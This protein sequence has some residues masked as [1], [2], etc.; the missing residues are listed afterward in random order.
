MGISRIL[1]VSGAANF[2]T[3]DVWEGYRIG[4][5]LIGLDVVPYPTFSMLKVLSPESVCSDILGTALDVDNRI[6]CVI[7]VDGLYFRGKRSR[8]PLS[9]R[10]AGIPT[11]LIATDDPYEEMPNVESLYT[12]RFTNELSCANEET[13]YLPTASLEFP[14]IQ[15]HAQPRYAVSFLGT[16]FEDRLPLLLKVA[17]HCEQEQKRFL[18]AGKILDGRKELGKFRMT[19]LREKTIDGPEK[20]EI[21]SNSIATLNIFR[22]SEVAESASP[23]VYE[24]TA[25]GHAS[26][27]TG[28]PRKEV[29]DLY[30]ENVVYFE[31]AESV[32]TALEEVWSDEE[33]RIKKSEQARQIT[34]NS[35]LYEHR[36]QRLISHLRTAERRSSGIQVAEH[37]IGWIIGCGRTGSTWLAEMLGDFPKIRKWHEP[38]FGRLFKHLQD[39]PDDYQ[40]P[41]SF[42]SKKHQ[43]VWLDGIRRMF[44]EMIEDRYP[45]FGEH[46]LAVKEV[47]T[48]ELYNWL[49]IL[50]PQG[51]MI[52][53]VRDPYDTLDSYLDLQKPGSWNDRFGDQTD[54]LKELNVRRT[55]KHI[56]STMELALQAYEAFPVEQKLQLSYED[57]L[58]DPAPHLISCGNLISAEVDPELAASI[59]EKHH[60]KKHQKTGTLEFRRKGRSG[61]WKESEN[62]TSEVLKIANEQLGPLRAKLGYH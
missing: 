59:A 7:F 50:F 19:D 20:W 18:I 30:G 49:A 33:T 55:A 28:P 36:A 31:D 56:R 17:Q 3:R 13:I 44:F 45:K 23:R 1:L 16:V 37:Q 46:S 11:V 21:Y 14:S 57:L 12:H 26:L 25:F 8:I 40:R 38:Y 58:R 27:V 22:E 4:L 39:R 32:I 9:I 52:H 10:R 29:R 24:V 54:P 47:N 34:L 15:R 42:F 6:D 41:A 43:K 61:V 35:H 5:S 48:P 62:F 53:L 60:F 2:S 51:R